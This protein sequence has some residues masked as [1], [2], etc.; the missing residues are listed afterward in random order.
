LHSELKTTSL[1]KIWPIRDGVVVDQRAILDRYIQQVHANG[2][3]CL[4][5][6]LAML[7]ML[8]MAEQKGRRSSANLETI[9][10]QFSANRLLGAE[11][12]LQ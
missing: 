8:A 11:Y 9:N 4:Q 6:M 3:Q 5:W 1:G 10:V 12:F 7:A 2:Q